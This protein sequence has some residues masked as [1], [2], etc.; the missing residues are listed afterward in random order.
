MD[1]FWRDNSFIP[2]RFKVSPEPILFQT[3]AYYTSLYYPCITMAARNHSNNIIIYN[4][5]RM[6]RPKSRHVKT[7][8]C[9]ANFRNKVMLI[10]FSSSLFFF[11]PYH[12]EYSYRSFSLRITSTVL[13]V[14][15]TVKMT[16]WDENDD[17]EWMSKK[18]QQ[19]QLKEWKNRQSSIINAVKRFVR[20]TWYKWI[21]YGQV[22]NLQH[23]L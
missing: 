16:C 23:F 8:V 10:S 2:K 18:Q 1:H 7:D 4:I 5:N 9:Q 6:Y 11:S 15:V 17:W 19:Q 22:E 13:T 14:K 21:T 20:E 12:D 3:F